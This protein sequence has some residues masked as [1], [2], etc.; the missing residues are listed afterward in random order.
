MDIDNLLRQVI[1]EATA[2]GIP[3]SKNINSKVIINSRAKTRF[4]CCRKTA[5]G[6][7]IE[8]S[9]RVIAAGEKACREVLSHEILHSCWG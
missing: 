2:L 8:L 1:A 9:D 6:F 4:G 7:V 3:V 5:E